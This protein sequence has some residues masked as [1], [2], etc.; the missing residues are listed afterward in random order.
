LGGKKYLLLVTVLTG[1]SVLYECSNK[2]REL[3]E[4]P[5][6]FETKEKQQ[7]RYDSVFGMRHGTSSEN[8]AWIHVV[9]YAGRAYPSYL[10]E[11]V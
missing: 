2:S 5:L 3:K 10:V 8:G 1:N 6:W 9:Y 4:P 7:V 11:Y